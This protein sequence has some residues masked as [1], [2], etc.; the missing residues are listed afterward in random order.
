MIITEIVAH[1]AI[2]HS[3]R[4]LENP[5]T[6][7]TGIGLERRFVRPRQETFEENTAREAAL[8]RCRALAARIDRELRKKMP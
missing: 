3:G 2:G 8:D 1:D 5:S 4:E 6:A 7:P